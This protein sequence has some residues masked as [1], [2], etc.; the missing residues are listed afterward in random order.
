MISCF[1]LKPCNK[2]YFK[3]V[4]KGFKLTKLVFEPKKGST[5]RGYGQP[6]Q[7]IKEPVDRLCL[8]DRGRHK[9][10][11]LFHWPSLPGRGDSLPDQGPVE[12]QR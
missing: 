4:L 1:Q 11:S 5:G 12:V 8:S 7:P 10:F 6:T 2:C 3:L 9:I